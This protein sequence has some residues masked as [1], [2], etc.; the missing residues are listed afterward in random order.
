V[1]IESPIRELL[2][3]M[4]LAEKI[5]QMCQVIGGGDRQ[6]DLIGQGRAGSVLNLG[7]PETPNQA[8]LSN[9]LQTIAAK[10]SRLGVPL[11][12]G[13]DVIHGFRTVMPIPLAQAA[14]L[15]MALVQ[16]AASVAAR[17]AAACGVNWTYA[18]MVD[19][20]RDPRWGRIA[21]GGGEDG[22]VT[23]R[24]GAAMVRGF[25]GGD[26]AHSER[27]AACAKHYVGY[28]AAEGGR[29]YNTTW[30]PEGLL[31][32]VYLPPFRACVDAGALTVMSALSDL[33]GRP[34]SGNR[35]ILRQILKGEWG[36]EGFV[37]SDWAS[38]EEMIAHGLCADKREAARAAV[39]AGVDMDI[40]STCYGENLQ[41]LV[42]DGLVPAALIDDAVTRLL[43]VKLRLGL[44][45]HPLTDESR[46]G[47]LLSDAHLDVARRLALESC[48]LL[49]NDGVLPLS[50]DVR[51]LAV[52][53]P[54][55]DAPADQLGCWSLD[56]VAGDTMTPARALSDALHGRC[57]VR[58]APGVRDCRSADE[59]GIPGACRIAAE[60]DAAVLFIGEDALLSG[61]AHS[62][63]FL[64]LPGAQEE[65]VSAVA[66]TGTP[67][68]AVIMSGRPL[69]LVNVL[70]R[71]SA[72]LMAWHPGTMG[73]PALADLLLGVSSPSG[74]LPVS[75]PRT[76]GQLPVY[77]D[78]KSTGRPVPPGK[79]TAPM[80]TPLD[81]RH[82]RS[83]Y[84]DLDHAPLFPFGFGLSYAAFSYSG[85]RMSRSTLPVGECL[86]VSVT[87]TNTS[88]VAADE[89]VQLYIRDPV[90][91]LTRPVK[92]LK[93]FTRVHLEPG[94]SRDVSFALHTDQL[95]F[96]N[97]GGERVV[98]PGVFHIMIGGGSEG[99]LRDE[100]IVAP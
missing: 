56:G 55:A 11:I 73:G 19:I 94:E 66:D 45:D 86:T 58:C 37:T 30:I 79:R 88:A 36:F 12:V 87:L 54:L 22:L 25:Q 64:D 10:E 62:R 68:I 28:G 20:A 84:L 26:S 9:E 85:L 7:G 17:E 18:P 24:L 48:V 69:T 33:N 81:P 31:R 46:R 6:R 44:F 21:E 41:K 60:C 8:G 76:A 97:E 4:T 90:A 51:S 40:A 47:V 78:H 29:D 98:E 34:A 93:D 59:S 77:Y 1:E 39:T 13:R 80:G 15:D 99:V 83:T 35:F 71:V 63:A 92:E 14:S 42:E 72:V 5:G 91:S 27:I 95:A 16:E 53:G 38:I 70:D 89:V 65:L 57:D 96:H 50:S 100:F 52:I 74:K 43:R 67:A 49:K 61:E 3:K 82:F 75:I 32:D 23:S 2:D